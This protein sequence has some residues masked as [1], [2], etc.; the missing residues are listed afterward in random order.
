MKKLFFNLL[1]ASVAILSLTFV[2]CKDDEKENEK[3]KDSVDVLIEQGVL[4]GELE[5]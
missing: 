5:P 3:T 4:T 1:V 2:A